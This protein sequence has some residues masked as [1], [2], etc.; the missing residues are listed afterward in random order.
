MT[1]RSSRPPCRAG[2]SVLDRQPRHD[3]AGSARHR[4]NLVE[5]PEAR[6]R[7]L[8]LLESGL[9]TIGHGILNE[10]YWPRLDLPQVRDLGFIV[11]DDDGFWSEVKR[12][13]THDVR[14]AEPGLPA[15][16]V[17]HD[18]PRYRLD[19]RICA[20]DD[21]DLVRVEAHLEDRLDPADPRRG[22]HPLRLYA[23]LAPRLGSSGRSNRAWVGTDR[24][25]TMLFAQKGS[26][27]M[28]LASEPQPDRQS[29][30][31]VGVSDGWTAFATNGRMTWAYP[32][33]EPGNVASMA[34]LI[35]GDGTA[36]L[37]LA[38]GTRPQEA[39]L[40]ACAALATHFEE[41]WE[42]YVGHWREFMKPL[43]RC[44][45]SVPDADRTLYLTSAA[46]LRV[47]ADRA[48]PGAIVASL[49][50]PW[51]DT[52]DDLGGYH[53]VWSRDL[54][55]VAGALVALGAG[56]AARHTLAYLVASQEPDGHWV[57]NQWVDGT[58]FWS[59]VQLDEAA[60]P[61]LLVGALRRGGAGD[62]HGM[63]ATEEAADFE[64]LLTDDAL[65]P[66]LSSLA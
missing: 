50:T 14:G 60:Y 57:Q 9:V 58:P 54:V 66:R 48:Q 25:R 56:T 7:R 15:I 37:V 2:R 1:R 42:A 59:G 40:Q 4:A 28:A 26:V 45:K 63:P 6:G 23:L 61:I 27:V 8:T 46:V 51:G 36:Q 62:M 34:E 32:D 31:F 41:A 39:A 20:D 47:L 38:F 29:V 18:H 22:A 53:L 24:G 19:L 33:T 3:G 12:D 5:Q 21:A 13:A 49:S 17:T 43:T 55:E 11:A 52:R 30:G 65:E 10:I 44:P 64:H 16:I 35:L